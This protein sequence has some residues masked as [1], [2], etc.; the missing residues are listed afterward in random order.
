MDFQ[1]EPF[2][3]KP[4]FSKEIKETPQRVFWFRKDNGE[5]FCVDEDQAWNIMKGRNRVM[6]ENGF[7]TITHE[8]LGSSDSLS[9]FAGLKEM[10]EIFAREGFEKSQ[11]FLRELH[12]KE[13]SLADKSIKPRNMD[14]RDMNGN[15]SNIKV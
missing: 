11:E 15:L 2:Q 4:S 7:K 3:T 5:E 10:R 9:F 1:N 6:T 8:Y 13:C 14:I 12:K